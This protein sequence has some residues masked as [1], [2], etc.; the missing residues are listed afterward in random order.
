MLPVT[1]EQSKAI[2][3]T[4]EFGTTA[5]QEVGALA[6]YMGRIIGTIPEDAVGLVLGDPLRAV[7]TIIAAKIDEQVQKILKDR[8]VGEPQ[9]VSPSLAIP[10][11]Q[12]A[13]DESRP[14]LQDLW[15]K[16]IAAAMDPTRSNRVRRS[17]I[18]TVKKLDPLDVLVLK[19]RYELNMNPAPSVRDYMVSQFQVSPEEIMVSVDNLVE[20]RCLSSPQ[21]NPANFQM[22]VYG[23][24]LVRACST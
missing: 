8:N 17:F 9:S 24:E 14:E 22:T 2:E 1:K 4:A 7:R 10:L 15:A 6:R 20:L 12:A 11:L 16:L 3:K 19:R 23:R 18:D 13:Y 21:M 5:I